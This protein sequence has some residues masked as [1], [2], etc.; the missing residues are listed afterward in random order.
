MFFFHP[1]QQIIKNNAPN[2]HKS[3]KSKA[4]KCFFLHFTEKIKRNKT[5]KEKKR[6][7]I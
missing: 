7:C 2:Y 5:K 6:N 3:N 1:S 4:V